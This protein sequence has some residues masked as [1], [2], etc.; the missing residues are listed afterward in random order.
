MQERHIKRDKYFEEQAITTE[1]YVLPFI[2]GV[3]PITLGIQVL[4]IGCGE[5]GNLKP[6]LEAGCIVT[7]VDILESKIDNARM[8][9]KDHPFKENLFLVRSDIYDIA[10]EFKEKFDIIFMRDVLEHIHDQDRFMSHVKT[11]LKPEG[12]F[13]LGF[14]PW[15]YP[16]GGH[17]Q[18]CKSWFLS[19]L[20]YFHLLPGSIYPKVLK[21]FGE[22][23]G[24]IRD[25]LEIRQTRI[26]I[27][28]F[29]RILIRENYRVRRKS[30]YLINPNYQVKFGLFPL[31]QFDFLMKIPWLRNYLVTT[32][33]YILSIKARETYKSLP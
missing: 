22:S 29:N 33:Y 11:F 15:Q 28:R 17:Q 24:L 6:F 19:R 3:K 18:M 25:L 2:G 4:E 10:D 32:C 31:K 30:F 21:W 8:F 27:E 13:F 20:P 23:Q 16:F 7:G 9:F 14:P 12:V 5:G 1:K 26:T